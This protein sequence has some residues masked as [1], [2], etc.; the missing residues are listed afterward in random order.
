MRHMRLPIICWGILL[1]ASMGFAERRKSAVA[2]ISPVRA[3]TSPPLAQLASAARA[4]RFA[5]PREINPHGSPALPFTA[6]SESDGADDLVASATAPLSSA[7]ASFLEFDGIAN[8]NGVAPP[9]TQGDVGKSHY[10]QWVNLSIQIFDKSTGATVIGPI[11]GNS[12]WAGFGGPCETTNNGDP[13]VLYDH[14]AD[15][16]FFSQFAIANDGHQCIAVSQTGDPTGAYHR[17][18]YIVT[19]GGLNDYP[20]FALWPDGYYYSVNQFTP[21]FSSVLMGAFERPKML[22][23]DPSAL[24]VFFEIPLVLLE[25]SLFRCGARESRGSY[26]ASRWEPRPVHPAG[27]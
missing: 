22:D 8:I 18:E 6:L 5:A 21:A 7:P 3:D 23:G 4:E 13:I 1:L 12:L 11:P 27:G 20:K 10:V 15:R 14:L 9:D 25:A 19:Q 17:Y 2:S 16:W 24:L 26:P